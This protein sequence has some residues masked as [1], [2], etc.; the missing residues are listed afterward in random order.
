MLF[1][2]F[3][4]SE[5]VDCKSS[6]GSDSEQSRAGG[7]KCE[8]DICSVVGVRRHGACGSAGC[9]STVTALT[10]V[11]L[12]GHDLKIEAVESTGESPCTEVE[13]ALNSRVGSGRKLG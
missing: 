11:V 3:W 2:L 9:P 5:H 10:V 8:F 12:V 4:S 6:N 7:V 1:S 13:A